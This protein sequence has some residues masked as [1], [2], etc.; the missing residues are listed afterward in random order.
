MRK[1]D[2]SVLCE[3]MIGFY[4]YGSGEWRRTADDLVLYNCIGRMDLESGWPCFI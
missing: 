2:D 1:S 4:V 3:R